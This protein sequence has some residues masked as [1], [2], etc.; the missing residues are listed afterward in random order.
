MHGH[1]PN[2]GKQLHQKLVLLHRVGTGYYF[3]HPLRQDSFSCQGRWRIDTI[4]FN[5][6]ELVAGKG[7][8]RLW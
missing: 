1:L 8:D 6:R 7:G 3:G 5:A 2:L 4:L